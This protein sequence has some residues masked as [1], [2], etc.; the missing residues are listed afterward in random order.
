MAS[1]VCQLYRIIRIRVGPTSY[2]NLYQNIGQAPSVHLA[3][4]KMLQTIIPSFFNLPTIMEV[5]TADTEQ[6]QQY[7][8]DPTTKAAP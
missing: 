3:T 5:G 8:S 2:C 4:A 7:K 6:Y 1:S